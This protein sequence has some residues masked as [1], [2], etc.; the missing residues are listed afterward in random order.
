MGYSKLMSLFFMIY[1]LM[2]SEN[3]YGLVIWQ[4][5]FG[6]V[7]FGPGICFGFDFGFNRLQ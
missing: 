6:A 4:G 1:H 2:L 3:S 7:N 5:I